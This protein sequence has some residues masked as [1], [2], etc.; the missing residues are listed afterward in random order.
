MNRRSLLRSLIS[1]PVAWPLVGQVLAESEDLSG[2]HVAVVGA[3]A[4]GGWTALALR[5]RGARVTLVEAHAAGH[6][7][8]SSGGE[9]R[10]IRHM[11]S[12]VRDVRMAARSLALWQQAQKSWSRRLLHVPGVLFMRQSPGRAFF[13]AAGRAM[14]EAG[15]DYETLEPGD[16]NRRWPMIRLDGIEAAAFE[17]QSGY[18]LARRACHA[19]IEAFERAGGDYQIAAA[20]PGPLTAGRMSAVQLGDGCR[21]EA[22]RIVFACGPWLGSLFPDLLAP[23]LRISR[24]EVFYFGT[25]AGDVRHGESEMPIWA[26]FGDKFWYGI[27]GSERRGFKIADDTLGPEIDPEHDDRIPSAEGIESARA[28]IAERFPA[29]SR[30][31]LVDARVCQYTN[32]PDG[33]FI[34][35][36]HPEAENVWFLGGGSGH[37]FKHGPA[38]G[39]LA[40]ASVLTDQVIEPG[41]ALG[42]SASA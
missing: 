13:E 19:V 37:G 4:F 25:P 41:F 38:L 35:D 42:R 26:D 40:A 7:R 12:N 5:Q 34:L 29:L 20:A 24:Q 21:L 36:R 2:L 27:P 33:A 3:G 11:Y 10:V 15:V 17:P 1:A 22:D 23:H 8:S 18:L 31:P 39:E 6:P 30:A 9:T 14:R 16:V 32:T 28:Y